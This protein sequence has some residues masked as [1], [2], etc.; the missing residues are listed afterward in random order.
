M[1]YMETGG[2]SMNA[3]AWA[4]RKGTKKMK[5]FWKHRKRKRNSQT[6]HKE[7]QT[8]YTKFTSTRYVSIEFHIYQM[9]SI[10]DIKFLRNVERLR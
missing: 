1:G 7:V 6:K 2:D 4:R 8:D 5:Y 10:S 9:F 3:Q